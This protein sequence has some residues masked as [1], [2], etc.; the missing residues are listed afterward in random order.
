MLKAFP[1]RTAR[2]TLLSTDVRSSSPTS[3]K[4]AK[5]KAMAMEV[6]EKVNHIQ[7]KPTPPIQPAGPV[8]PAGGVPFQD[9]LQKAF[10]G[11]KLKLSG[12]AAKRLER[13]GISLT[14][15]DIAKLR[16]AVD[17]AQSKGSRDSLVL[18]NDLAFVVSVKN[19]TIL[20]AMQTKQMK[21]SIFTNIDSTVIA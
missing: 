10:D 3:L 7:I 4:S 2:L 19:N 11:K 20:T 6:H 13:R 18:L 9:E 1:M 17:R 8:K 16:D 12:H 14:D 15:S 21:E 5:V